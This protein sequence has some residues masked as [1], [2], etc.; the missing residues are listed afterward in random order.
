MKA[1]IDPSS[2]GPAVIIV[3]S[4]L[5]VIAAIAV[6]LRFWS[7]KLTGLGWATDDYFALIAF[8]LQTAIYGLSVHAVLYGGLGRDLTSVL[9]DTPDATTVLLKVG[10]CR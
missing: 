7:R 9:A 4:V 1:I 2:S 6:G 5:A 8:F 10:F 3:N